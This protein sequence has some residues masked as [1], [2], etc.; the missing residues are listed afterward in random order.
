[1]HLKACVNHLWRPG[2][3]LDVYT[4]D[5]RRFFFKFGSKEECTR[6]LQTGPWL[7]DGRLIILK[8]WRP[9]I[10]LERDLHSSVPIWIRFPYL[11]LKF[12]SQSILS[13]L[14]SLV[15]VSLL[16]DKATTAYKRLEHARCFVEISAKK[17]WQ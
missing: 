17:P 4:R 13:K 8:Q 5:N 3:S 14:A 12:W 11:H 10:G 9:E 7:F 1:M 2:C 6:V 15:G 16:M